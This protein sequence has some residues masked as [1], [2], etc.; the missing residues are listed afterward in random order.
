MK[1]LIPFAVILV[2]L[3]LSGSSLAQENKKTNPYDPI[4]DDPKLPRVL[5]IGDSIATEYTLPTRK[6]LAGKANVHNVGE[7]AGATLNGMKKLKVWLGE[8]KWDVIHF[9]WGLNDI[10]HGN[11]K[12]QVPIDEYQTNL[13]ELLKT[14]K[15]TGAR[16]IFATTTPV[17]AGNVKP[18][19]LTADVIVYNKAAKKIMAE[20]GV[21]INDLYAFALPQLDKIQQPVNVHFTEE[22]SAALADRVA[23]AIETALKK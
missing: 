21:A 18:L 10:R 11:G 3:A 14:M 2:L 6:L 4:K 9:N 1:R 19:R 17:P 7:N 8:A 16:V 22:G 13:R 12:N 15:G 23:A 5:L 20:N